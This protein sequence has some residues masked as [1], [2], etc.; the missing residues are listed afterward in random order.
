MK[1]LKEKLD[2]RIFACEDQKHKY[3]LLDIDDAKEIQHLLSSMEN[4]PAN[5]TDSDS[6]FIGPEAGLDTGFIVPEPPNSAG[7]KTVHKYFE[8]A[9]P[10]GVIVET[11]TVDIAIKAL[12]AQA[13]DFEAQSELLKEAVERNEELTAAFHRLMAEFKTVDADGNIAAHI[14][15]N[16]Y[17]KLMQF[18]TK[19]IGRV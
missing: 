1:E 8:E 9:R 11:G 6:V 2:R 7:V 14:S 12:T 18:L 13:K 5:T 4:Q 3:V 19:H 16:R 15:K 10:D 17:E